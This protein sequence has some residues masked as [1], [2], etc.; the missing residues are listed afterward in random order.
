LN[1]R[2]RRWISIRGIPTRRAPCSAYWKKGD[3][4]RHFAENLKHAE[5]HGVPTEVL[6]R[7]RQ[8]F[9][10]EGRAGM[11]KLALYAS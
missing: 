9:A 8:I 7:L 2:T 5:L 3:P 1:G 10:A 4:D 11:L 6:E